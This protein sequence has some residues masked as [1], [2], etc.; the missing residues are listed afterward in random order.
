MSAS[1]STRTPGSERNGIAAAIA[2]AAS[3][4]QAGVRQRGASL[5][6]GAAQLD[7]GLLEHAHSRSSSASGE[8]RSEISSSTK[9]SGSTS[10]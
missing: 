1:A 3:A 6:G 8:G 10:R 5:A 2:S 7:R 9:A 4:S